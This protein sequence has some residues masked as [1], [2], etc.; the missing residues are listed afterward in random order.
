MTAVLHSREA[1]AAAGPLVAAGLLTPLGSD[2]LYARSET[3]ELVTSALDQLL[4]TV[5]GA[6]PR[7]TLRF[8]PLLTASELEAHAYFKNFPQLAA[9]VYACACSRDGTTN[10]EAFGD[11]FTPSELAMLPAACYPLYPLVAARGRHFR[12]PAL[13]D[14]A[15]TCFR[16]E[17]SV[18]P[19]R[20]QSFRM[21]EFVL[22]G[23]GDATAAFRDATRDASMD[24]L[25]CLGLSC[26]LEEASDPFFGRTSKILKAA[27]LEA[28]A[29]FELVADA[30]PYGR[31]AIASFNSHGD[32]FGKRWQLMLDA[33]AP[34]T[35]CCN[36]YG[37]DRIAIA[38][39][40][41]HGF[42]PVDWPSAV[43]QALGFV[44]PR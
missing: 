24:L 4:D 29:K 13:F 25:V 32:L 1:T 30:P 19:W 28:A 39:F 5:P 26:T 44:P 34:A 22:V 7:E 23:P 2:G 9:R 20:M 21:R 27:Q 3:Y 33:E 35:S 37:I 36:A 11:G 12:E 31:F 38:L 18:E 6:M 42:D 14:V 41:T 17:P 15:S 10:A 16:N 8:P 40:L 43:R